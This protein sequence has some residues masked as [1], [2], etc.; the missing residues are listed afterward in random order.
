MSNFVM[1]PVDFDVI[2]GKQR[3]IC[4]FRLKDWRIY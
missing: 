4:W 3:K 1:P 2:I